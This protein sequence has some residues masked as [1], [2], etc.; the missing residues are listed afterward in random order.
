MGS[1]SEIVN[2]SNGIPVLVFIMLVLLGLYWS[3]K[4]GLVSFKGKGLSVGK[5]RENE[6]RIIREQ[7]QA[8]EYMADASINSLPEELR[9]GS[10]YYRAKYVIAK[11][12][13]LM[14]QCIIYNHITKDPI[15]IRL[16]QDEAY[17]IIMKLTDDKFFR[18]PEFKAYLNDL[19]KSILETCV[20][21]RETYSKAL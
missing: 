18:T 12:R 21:V 17:N 7:M 14:E 19:V 20:D 4:R 6:L 3:A 9:T 13:D 8:M 5:T 10:S 2:G 15:Y 16:K 11:F 1:I